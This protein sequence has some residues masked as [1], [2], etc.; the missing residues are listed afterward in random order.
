MSGR[1]EEV[2]QENR[3]PLEYRIEQNIIVNQVV[4]FGKNFYYE[5]RFVIGDNSRSTA[6]TRF[7][8][9]AGSAGFLCRLGPSSDRENLQHYYGSQGLLYYLL[10]T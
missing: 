5:L 9:C 1:V 7:N 4:S 10:T 8:E 6:I 3:E 2:H